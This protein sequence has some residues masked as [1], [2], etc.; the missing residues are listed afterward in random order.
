MSRINAGRAVQE[1]KT[2]FARVKT[3]KRIDID[4]IPNKRLREFA[5]QIAGGHYV[6]SGCAGTR[7][8]A[9]KTI[10]PARLK[11]A[12]AKVSRDIAKADANKDKFI[13][14]T[15]GKKLSKTAAELLNYTPPRA[16]RP[17]PRPSP[18]YSGC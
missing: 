16:S 9:N 6:S 4:S 1:L 18:V 8:V 3:E 12:I 17:A 5:K 7:Y 2:Q 13:T 10:T 11:A 14:P 15:E